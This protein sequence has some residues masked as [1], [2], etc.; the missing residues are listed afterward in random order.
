MSNEWSPED[1]AGYIPTEEGG[2]KD[3]QS[4][5]VVVYR[6]MDDP[7]PH[8]EGVYRSESNAKDAMR[9]C[10]STWEE[11][12]DAVAWEMEKEEIQNGE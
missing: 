10:E 9:R 11:P 5:W 1:G 6:R 2:T 12:K 7:H 3:S 8:C 4:V